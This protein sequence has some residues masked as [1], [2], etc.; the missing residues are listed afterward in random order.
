MNS[1]FFEKSFFSSGK[2]LA[3]ACC[4]ISFPAFVSS[5]NIINPAEPVPAYLHVDSF[6]VKT[7][8]LTQGSSSHRIVDAWVFVDGNIVGAFEMPVNVPVLSAGMHKVTVRPGILV[9]GIAATRSIYPFYSGYDTVMNL[10][11]AK[12]NTAQS[13]SAVQRP[14][15]SLNPAGRWRRR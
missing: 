5:C 12:I 13:N 15:G 3:Y 10:E 4:F 8:P 6:S 7:D 14:A 11:S 2:K 1:K 9:N